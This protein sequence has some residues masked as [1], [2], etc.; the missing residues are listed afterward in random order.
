MQLYF[1][2]HGQSGNNLLWQRTGSSKGRSEDPELT[3]VGRQQA[4]AL[5]QHLRQGS[6]SAVVRGLDAQNLTGFGITHLYTSLMVR[7]VATGTIIAQ[8]LRL[9]LVAWEDLHEAGGLYQEDEQTGERIG[10]SG[11]NRTFFET[12]FPGLVLPESLGEAGWWDRP[13]E[14]YAER[15]GR[16]QRFLRDLLERHGDGED[17]V[18][19]VSHAGFYNYLMAIVLGLPEQDGYW[20]VLNN[21][22]VTRIDF[23]PEGVALVYLN[24]V[25]FLP[26]ALVT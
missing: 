14:E 13:F 12:Y 1:I 22:A 25:D 8:A 11:K 16:A 9:P 20:F 19:V 21:A 5:A 18:V 24:R 4:E 3:D 2:R 15:P 6:S 17:R 26:R 7:A 23:G 10:V